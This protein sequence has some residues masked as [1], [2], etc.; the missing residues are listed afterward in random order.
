MESVKNAAKERFLDFGHA[1][2]DMILPVGSSPIGQ[3]AMQGLSNLNN[4]ISQMRTQET[5]QS[6]LPVNKE[7]LSVFTPQTQSY[8]EKIPLTNMKPQD[9]QGH[10]EPFAVS[11]RGSQPQRIAIDPSLQQQSQPVQNEVLQHEYLHEIPQP[12][13]FDSSNFVRDMNLLQRENPETY[14]KLEHVANVY[15]MQGM[16]PYDIAQELYAQ[17]GA[18]LKSDVHKTSIGKY[19]KNIIEEKK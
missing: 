3:Q 18:L 4:M 8:A 10:D 11:I 1:G 15:S 16:K 13:G 7:A 12:I 6:E 5:P 19:Y 9:Y 17:A 14:A 2:N